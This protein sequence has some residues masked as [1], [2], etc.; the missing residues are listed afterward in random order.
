M[1]GIDLGRSLLAKLDLAGLRPLLIENRR[2]TTGTTRWMADSPSFNK[3]QG[4]GRSLWQSIFMS[5]LK[6]GAGIGR[7]NIRK[8][9]RGRPV[10]PKAALGDEVWLK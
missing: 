8:S 4:E 5:S 10:S 3:R 9:A 7:E 2:E 6:T 1:P